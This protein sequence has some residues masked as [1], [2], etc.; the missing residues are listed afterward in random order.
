M[1]RLLYYKT[2]FGESPL[3]YLSFIETDIIDS[4]VRGRIYCRTPLHNSASQTT[5]RWTRI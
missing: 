3:T 5:L 2:K 4:C 1:K